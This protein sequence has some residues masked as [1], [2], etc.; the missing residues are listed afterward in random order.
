MCPSILST[1][2]REEEIRFNLP[3]KKM[4]KV[5]TEYVNEYL[6]TH[7]MPKV[8]METFT[9]L[10]DFYTFF[11]RSIDV[12]RDI[13]FEGGE[14]LMMEEHFKVLQLLI[15]LGR[16][17]V[18]IKYATNLTRLSFKDYDILD[19]WKQFKNVDIS[20]S[21]DAMG[22]KNNYIRNPSRFYDIV[23]NINKIKKEAPHVSIGINTTM[24]ILTS[25]A[26]SQTN[27]FCIENN[28][29][30]NFIFLHNPSH[31]S[32]TVLPKHVK[33]RVERHWEYHIQRYPQYTN[34]IRGFISMMHGQDNSS[35]IP[36]F[37]DFMK[38]RD[39]VRGEE[40]FYT[41]PELWDIK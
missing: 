28:I 33:E 13:K 11:N 37:L 15:E 32:M 10:N 35:E 22:E 5:Q 17:D 7:D 30:Q 8:L 4:S 23:D 12:V 38:E 40:F 24:Q 2:N 34:E 27:V 19:L 31:M 9:D 25:F 36:E 29:P 14:P 26:A 20:V 21:M 41:F 1:T 3:L 39:T 18:T 16:T 6:K